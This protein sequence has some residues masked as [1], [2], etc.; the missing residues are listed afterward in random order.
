MWKPQLLKRMLL[1]VL[2]LLALSAC[3]TPVGIPIKPKISK[4]LLE[5][6]GGLPKLD[7]KAGEPIE[8]AVLRNRALSESAM[9][10]C[11]AKHVGV[12]TSVGVK[13][14]QLTSKWSTYL[15][16]L[17]SLIPKEPK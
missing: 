3:T 17:Q 12:L 9:T 1:S 14:T 7:A 8:E 4:E 2:L 11:S 15:L 16:R 13:P 6:C 10:L 5:P